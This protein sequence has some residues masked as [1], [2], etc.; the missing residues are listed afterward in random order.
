MAQRTTK[1][2]VIIIGAG[3]TGLSAAYHLQELG[4][5]HILLLDQGDPGLN[6][7][8]AGAGYIAGGLLDN[9]TRIE[10]A[11][12]EAF[13]HQLWRLGDLAFDEILIFCESH[14]IGTTRGKRLRL[15][16]SEPE[17]KE[18]QTATKLMQS[19][20]LPAKLYLRDQLPEDLRVFRERVLAVQ[21]DGDRSAFVDV[22]TCL[23]TLQTKIKTKVTKYHVDVV[24]TDGQQVHVQNK[25]GASSYT[26]QM[27]VVCNH[28]A[29][30][31]L[32]PTMRAALVSYADQW[33]RYNCDASPK[34]VRALQGSF[35][36]ANHTH[37]WGIMAPNGE[38]RFGGGRY[39][40][41]M[42]G[43]EAT[44]ASYDQKIESHLQEQIQKTF[45]LE[46]TIAASKGGA[47][48]ECRPCDEL[49][50]IGPMF[51]EDRVL[52]AS[53]YMG[54]GLSLGFFAGKRLAELLA[55]GQARDL[56]DLLLP[57]R[58]RSLAEGS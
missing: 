31:D 51:G 42:A 28:L 2:D 52:L 40:R 41:K 25:A 20:G 53:G 30:G 4:V 46:S 35:I 5:H 7:S 8:I 50:I 17:L 54:Q 23:R 55:K 18:A 38:L 57:R 13:A 10:N 45:A 26:G 27:V 21:V 37:E 43:I 9:F 47:S 19:G 1:F 44:E 58:L 34:L 36:S 6:G 32:L 11:H 39:L 14:K 29:I 22:A 12:G 48:L 24:R 3:I 33:G 56:L 15:I 16:T 49:P